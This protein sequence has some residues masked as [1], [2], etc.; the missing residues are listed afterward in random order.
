MTRHFKDSV[1]CASYH[2]KWQLLDLLYA[3]LMHH[4][5]AGV[6][7]DC[8]LAKSSSIPQSKR[9]QNRRV[10]AA[11]RV[12]IRTAIIFYCLGALD[13]LETIDTQ[14]TE[15]DRQTWKEWLWEQQI[16]SC[17]PQCASKR[18]G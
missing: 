17:M 13:I 8:R 4:M 10:P 16:C 1:I 3:E 5:L 2:A 9:T 11:K 12:F 6:S 14:T 18:A 15:L 7:S